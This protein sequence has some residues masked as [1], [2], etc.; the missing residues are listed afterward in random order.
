MR[1]TIH[2]QT[3]SSLNLSESFSESTINRRSVSTERSCWS[4]LLRIKSSVSIDP[5]SLE[6][7]WG[8]FPS[9]RLWGR[10]RSIVDEDSSGFQRDSL[11]EPLM[12][13]PP[14]PSLDS[15]WS[16]DGRQVPSRKRYPH[17]TCITAFF[18]ELVE[19]LSLVNQSSFKGKGLL[20]M[21][22]PASQREI[23]GD[24]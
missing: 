11:S 9:T 14:V 17:K 21:S 1:I 16:C 19:S 13:L 4:I 10:F 22:L 5:S 23:P 8:I 6:T 2:R 18:E 7:I 20:R 12:N 15:K 24:F 3:I